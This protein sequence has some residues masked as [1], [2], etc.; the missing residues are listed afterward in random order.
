VIECKTALRIQGAI[1]LSQTKS[2]I[3][4]SEILSSSTPIPVVNQIVIAQLTT[5]NGGS[6]DGRELQVYMPVVLVLE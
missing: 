3:D 5:G 4:L 2:D 1:V 6:R